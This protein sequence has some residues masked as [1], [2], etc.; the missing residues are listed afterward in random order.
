MSELANIPPSAN[1]AVAIPTDGLPTWFD[2][3]FGSQ[4][5][6]TLDI[7]TELGKLLVMEAKMAPGISCLDSVGKTIEIQDI[8]A[9][10]VDF[11][12][13]EGEII[14]GVRTCLICRDGSIYTS[15]SNGIRSAVGLLISVYGLRTYDP[16]VAMRIEQRKANSGFRYLTLVPVRQSEPEQPKPKK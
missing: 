16:A 6:T 7:K 8:L 12:G 3:G 9:H 4:I 1:N 14:Q 5:L 10:P 13:P 2:G 11:R 15:V